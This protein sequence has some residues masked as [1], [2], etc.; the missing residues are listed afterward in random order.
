MCFSKGLKIERKNFLAQAKATKFFEERGRVSC[1]NRFYETI[2]K[3][4]SL[5]L[6]KVGLKSR[7]AGA[8]GEIIAN[9]LSSLLSSKFSDVSS[10]DR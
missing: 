2:E 9:L 6:K 3:L 10:R 7:A 5:L 1:S 8:F 4:V